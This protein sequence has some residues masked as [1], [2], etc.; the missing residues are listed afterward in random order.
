MND[1]KLSSELGNWK[2]LGRRWLTILSAGLVGNLCLI[3]FALCGLGDTASVARDLAADSP[4]GDLTVAEPTDPAAT[5]PAA[6]NDVVQAPSEEPTATTVV[7]TQSGNS[8]ATASDSSEPGNPAAPQATPRSDGVDAETLSTAAPPPDVKIPA[9][10]K[11]TI[12][13]NDAAQVATIIF[14]PA[15]TGGTVHFVV[16]GEIYSLSPA[17]YRC[18]AGPSK[19]RVVFHKGDELIDVAQE[20]LAGEFAFAVGS[21]GWEL[22]AVDPITGKQLKQSCRSA[23][24]KE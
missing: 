22:K 18:F 9:E 13:I 14:N 24:Q 8:A 21:S 1:R 5:S 10:L 2:K 17:E 23:A 4:A 12:E 19:K 6:T 3:A 11:E 16:D 15:T 20:V 7:K